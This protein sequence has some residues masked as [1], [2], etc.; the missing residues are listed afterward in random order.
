MSTSASLV[1]HYSCLPGAPIIWCHRA[2]SVAIASKVSMHRT[3][4]KFSD[5]SSVFSNP[6]TRASS[7]TQ[8]SESL[9]T[10]VD[11]FIHSRSRAASPPSGEL[12][13]FGKS[14]RS[15]R[16]SGYEGEYDGDDAESYGPYFSL[17]RDP[18]AKSTP[19]RRKTTKDLIGRYESL[20]T[21][22]TSTNR[23]KGS[24]MTESSKTIPRS[25]PLVG[26]KGKGKSPLRQSFRNLMAVFSKKP[27]IV[28]S[29]TELPVVEER[30]ALRKVLT[31]QIPPGGTFGNPFEPQDCT[32]PNAIRSGQ[33][34]RLC[35]D[36]NPSI[37]PVWIDCEA[38]LHPH[39]LLVIGETS[40]RNS[41]TSMITFTQCTDVRSV[42]MSELETT[43]RRLL[44]GKPDEFKV[45]EL[46]FEGRTREKFA[47]R[48][49]QD[50][51]LWVN[52]IWWVHLKPYVRLFLM[53]I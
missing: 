39:H 2:N 47:S 16:E 24:L 15:S 50:R 19:T 10:P 25:P 9:V 3:H 17:P 26:K 42:N 37:L 40:Q 34:L 46:L 51:A 48:S 4:T 7:T 41:S 1:P 31:L 52:S 14:I 29:K 22:S 45:F 27:K 28:E 35:R 21:S 38:T 5:N 33:L 11:A 8:E 53:A 32:S 36:A 13:V 30:D 18:T 49:V 23:T 44:P 6:L 20:S 12:G 43:E